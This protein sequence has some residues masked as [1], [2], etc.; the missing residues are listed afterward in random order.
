MDLKYICESCGKIIDKVYEKEIYKMR[1]EINEIKK[2][3]MENN[4]KNRIILG[5]IIEDIDKRLN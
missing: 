4:N 5:S 3:I 1:A 2:E